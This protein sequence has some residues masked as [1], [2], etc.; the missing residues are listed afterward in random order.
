MSVF[1]VYVQCAQQYKLP[2]AGAMEGG[3]V[4]AIILMTCI[5]L[6][7]WNDVLDSSHSQIILTLCRIYT[8][9]D[10]HFTS[11]FYSSHNSKT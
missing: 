11:L 8:T 9:R 7:I 1:W 4:I 3:M 2:Q 5:C 10:L 6:K